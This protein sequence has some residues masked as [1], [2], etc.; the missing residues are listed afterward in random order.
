MIHL[1]HW[2]DLAWALIRLCL[3]IG[4][5]WTSTG[6]IQPV[7]W[8]D[9]A[10]ALVSFSLLP[11]DATEGMTLKKEI[12]QYKLVQYKYSVPPKSDLETIKVLQ[13]AFFT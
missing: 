9:S 4:A 11:I 7:H 12:S 10:C 6:V 1:A 2:C 5:I 3:H 13:F 8:C